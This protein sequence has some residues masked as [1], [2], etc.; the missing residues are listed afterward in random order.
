MTKPKTLTEIL[1]QKAFA[2]YKAK[3]RGRKKKNKD[4]C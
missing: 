4:W 1:R 2:A 3:K